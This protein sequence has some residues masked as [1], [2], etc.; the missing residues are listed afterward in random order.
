[1]EIKIDPRYIEL[2]AGGSELYSPYRLVKGEDGVY[3]KEVNASK[4]V[5][6]NGEPL[7][8]YHGG[9][10][11]IIAFDYNRIGQ[12]GRSEG[13]GFEFTENKLLEEYADRW[14]F[15]QRFFKYKK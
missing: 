11:N 14:R 13:A 4:V 3:S 6:E 2:A 7:V 8:V 5:D 10:K 15:I 9:G 1:M 12:Q